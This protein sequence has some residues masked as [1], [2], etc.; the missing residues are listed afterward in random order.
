MLCRC[1]RRNT[2]HRNAVGD[3]PTGVHGP[4]TPLHIPRPKRIAF[5]LGIYFRHGG[6]FGGAMGCCLSRS[7]QGS[8]AFD[9]YLSCNNHNG[10]CSIAL[11]VWHWRCD[12]SGFEGSCLSPALSSLQVDGRD[13]LISLH[14]QCGEPV[15]ESIL[16]SLRSAAIQ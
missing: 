1:N 10:V 12:C 6:I 8:G 7:P 11:C 5:A 3:G 9:S 4:K 15:F 14:W 16:A 2:A 13:F